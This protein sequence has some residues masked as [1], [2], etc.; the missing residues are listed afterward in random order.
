MKIS[1]YTQ[2][3]PRL[4]LFFIEEWIDHHLKF[5]VDEIY[6]YNNGFVSTQSPNDPD[7]EN[8]DGKKWAKKPD[9]DYCDE[10]T[11][12]EVLSKLN[13]ILKKFEGS[14]R[15]VDW[16]PE[17]ECPFKS[18]VVCQCAGYHHSVESN[19]SDWWVSIDPDEYLFS[20]KYTLKEFV[21]KME[22]QDK[23]SLLLSQ[24]VFNR[25]VRNQSVKEIFEWGYDININ[26]TI[27]KSPDLHG[28][29][30]GGS[31]QKDAVDRDKFIHKVPS[32]VGNQYNVPISDFR[33][34]HYRGYTNAN[35][36]HSVYIKE[37]NCRFDKIDKTMMDLH[38]NFY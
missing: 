4:E 18:R 1:I 2:I 21:E 8:H 28:N 22:K 33:F 35:D 11:D 38:N 37:H 25:R 31:D 30:S 29:P 16:R 12:D 32:I 26:K 24:R 17:I 23:H 3:F 27:V 36:R 9:A 15:L 19:Q 7:A 6:I 34:N 5:G 14:V 13:D 20:S 10:Y